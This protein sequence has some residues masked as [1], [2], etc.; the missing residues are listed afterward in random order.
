MLLSFIHSLHF[1]WRI[2]VQ[3]LYY[4]R[5]S[6]SPHGNLFKIHQKNGLIMDISRYNVKI[7][8]SSRMLNFNPWHTTTQLFMYRNQIS[9]KKF[10]DSRNTSWTFFD[11]GIWIGFIYLNSYLDI[12]CCK[13]SNMYINRHQDW[14]WLWK[15]LL[16]K[17]R[18]GF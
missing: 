17:F 16:L 3:I 15:E 10:V 14:Y 13:I 1:T 8:K 5:L 7:I 6:C 2:E 9:Y 4:F 18:F 11:K 12:N